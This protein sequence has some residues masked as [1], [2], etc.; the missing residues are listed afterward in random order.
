MTEMK[1]LKEKYFKEHLFKNV[2]ELKRKHKHN[3]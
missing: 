2:Q 1:E 3:E